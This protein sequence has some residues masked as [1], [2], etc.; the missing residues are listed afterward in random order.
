MRALNT[1]WRISKDSPKSPSNADVLN[2]IAALNWKPDED[3]EPQ[4]ADKD[5]RPP[6]EPN[7]K[8]RDDYLIAIAWFTALNP[9]ELW[10]K[11]RRMESFNRAQY[12]L[13]YRA[14]DPPASWSYMANKWSTTPERAKR[15]YADALEQV[16]RAA[17]GQPVLRH[18]EVA[19]QIGQLR[20]RNRRAKVKDS[21]HR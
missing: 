14:L 13:V 2:R 18:V 10:P 20:K 16:W 3:E 5:W 15:I 6:F 4:V 7:G 17:N 8:D 9:P 11:K 19:D 12:A 1:G 21:N